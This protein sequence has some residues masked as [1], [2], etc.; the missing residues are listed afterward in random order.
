LSTTS[1]LAMDDTSWGY[2]VG[3]GVMA[4]FGEHFGVRGDVRYY[5]S[6]PEVTFLGITLPSEKL[7]FSRIGAGIVFQF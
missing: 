6:F 2:V 4:F 3:G 1:L 7:N 5:H